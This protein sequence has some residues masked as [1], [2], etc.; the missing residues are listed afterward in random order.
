MCT[1]F[2]FFVGL[3]ALG[4]YIVLG[5]VA[6]AIVAVVIVKSMKKRNEQQGT[7]MATGGN[8]NSELRS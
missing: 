5:L 6:L 4:V 2:I 1:T 8:S 3:L 7:Q